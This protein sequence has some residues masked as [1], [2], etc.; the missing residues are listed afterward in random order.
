MSSA[1]WLPLDVRW[2]SARIA[3]ALQAAAALAVLAPAD[4]ISGSIRGVPVGTPVL[5]VQ[6]GEAG[7]CPFDA[8]ALSTEFLLTCMLANAL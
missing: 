8:V 6:L 5:P 7:V 2:P 1:A 3:A 4:S